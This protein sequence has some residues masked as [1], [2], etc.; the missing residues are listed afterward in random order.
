MPRLECDGREVP[1]A[2][3]ESVL[4]ALLRAGV[5]VASS[6]RAGAC[7]SCLVRVTSGAV[8]ARAQAGLKETLRA[9]GFALACQIV[10]ETALAISLEGKSDLEVAARVEAVDRLAADVLCVRLRSETELAY[11]AGQFVTLLRSDGLARAYSL[12]SRPADGQLLE[13][14]VRVVAGGRMSN[15]LATEATGASVRLRGPA[16]DCFYTSTDAEQPLV[17]AGAGTGLAPL[18]GILRDA[19]AA[20]HRGAIQLWHGARDVE[21]LYLRAEL[22]QLSREHP[23]FSYHPCA[24]AGDEAGELRIGRLDELL[25]RA[26]PSY[27]RQRFYLCGD[28]PLVQ[29]LKRKLFLQGA[30]LREIFADAFLGASAP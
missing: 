8:P 16:G 27:A 30:P 17:L 26:V 11:R 25:L 6:C 20:G 28:A 23:H 4:D 14:H 24:L 13:L 3:G 9:R 21:G 10:P 19:L 15:W 22:A 12:A 29:G 7:Q 1:L 18:W 2:E 5:E